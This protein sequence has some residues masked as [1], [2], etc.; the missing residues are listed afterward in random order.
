MNT[1]QALYLIDEQLPG[2]LLGRLDCLHIEASANTLSSASVAVAE[3]LSETWMDYDHALDA[4]KASPALTSR[5]RAL[6]A[7]TATLKQG[8]DAAVM[9]LQTIIRRL[10]TA[11]VILQ[12]Q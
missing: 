8:H 1:L 6:K 9:R 4:L 11:A 3:M 5:P 12:Q 2:E 10:D 7:L